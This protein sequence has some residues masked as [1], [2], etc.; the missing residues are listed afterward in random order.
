MPPKALTAD[1]QRNLSVCEQRAGHPDTECRPT[2]AAA[3]SLS[4]RAHVLRGDQRAAA[5]SAAIIDVHLDE[6]VPD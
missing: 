4:V 5:A 2:Q 6:G 3:A 1:P